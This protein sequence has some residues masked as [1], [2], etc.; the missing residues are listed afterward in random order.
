MTE[1]LRILFTAI[2]G[3]LA[4]FGFGVLFGRRQQ[5]RL[6]GPARPL[7]IIGPI[8]RPRAR[9]NAVRGRR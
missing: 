3:W 2:L 9:G 8:P 1:L 6:M 7:K 5:R 4:G